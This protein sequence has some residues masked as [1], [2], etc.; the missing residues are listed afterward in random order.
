MCCNVLLCYGQRSGQYVAALGAPSRKIV[1]GCQAAALP[2]T[3]RP[4]QAL[5][6]RIAQRQGQQAPHYLYV[7]RLAPEKAVPTLIAAFG[8]IYRSQPQ[9]QLTLVGSG[10]MQQELQALV[11]SLGLQQAVHFAGAAGIDTLPGYFLDATCLVLPSRREPWGL[12]VN[13]ALSYG[14]PAVVSDRCG[15]APDLIVQGRTGYEFEC[16]NVAD[17]QARMLQTGAMGDVAQVAQAC[18]SQMQRFTPEQAARK[19]LEGCTMVLTNH[20]TIL[21]PQTDP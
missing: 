3:Y 10:P 7:G 11:A 2:H 12:V 4:E 19:I 21:S 16:D 6:Q 17:L 5:Q 14:C 13:E 15:C 18:I 1:I 9:A 8:Q 20:P